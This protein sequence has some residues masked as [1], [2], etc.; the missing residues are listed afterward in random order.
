MRET[1][2]AAVKKNNTSTDVTTVDPIRNIS[3]SGGLEALAAPVG[4]SIIAKRY[5]ITA[6]NFPM[7]M[8]I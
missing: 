4:E 1:M 3:K 5:A 2:S 6:N 7:M 8:P